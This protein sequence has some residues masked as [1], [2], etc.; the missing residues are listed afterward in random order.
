[1]SVVCVGDDLITRPDESYR[2]WFVVVCDLETSGMRRPWPTGGCRAKNEQT[3]I[4]S[5]NVLVK[6]INN[7]TRLSEDIHLT[8]FNIINP[9]YV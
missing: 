7:K 5:S 4:I 9:F 3:N 2:L 8:Q 6:F 1:M